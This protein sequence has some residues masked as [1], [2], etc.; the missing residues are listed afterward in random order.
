MCQY[1]RLLCKGG[2]V[3]YLRYVYLFTHTG[4]QHDFHK[5]M[6]VYFNLNMTGASSGKGNVY[7]SGAP[8]FT[9]GF[10]LLD[11]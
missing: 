6:I 4:V 2:V 10:L 5:M 3:Y 9:P 8:G 11:F 1:P 7:T